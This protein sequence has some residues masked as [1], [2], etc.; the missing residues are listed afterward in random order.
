MTISLSQKFFIGA[1]IA[2]AFI[3]PSF[4]YAATPS[5]ATI[6][7]QYQ[8]L[9]E[10]FE[11]FR[12]NKSDTN[13]SSTAT[14]TVDKKVKIKLPVDKTCMA[15]LVETREA[16]L[17]TAWTTYNDSVE[18]AFDERT[19]A[20]VE[21]WNAEDYRS[22]V[23]TAWAEWRSDFKAANTTFKSERRKAWDTFKNDS[24]ATCK[25]SAPSEEAMQK[26]STGSMSI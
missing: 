16:S 6:Q 20:L 17:K 23:K 10:R 24:K 18:S 9:M 7:S 15:G 1:I 5:L 25:V 2:I 4:S 3:I 14:T 13:A 12:K 11:N 26:D 22:A 8:M 21:A 19:S